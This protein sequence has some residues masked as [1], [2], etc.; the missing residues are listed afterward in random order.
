MK[1]NLTVIGVLISALLLCAL[2][3][4]ACSDELKTS[5]NNESLGTL[6]VQI[7]GEERTIAPSA[8]GLTYKIIISGNTFINETITGTKTYSLAPGSYWL[9]AE[10]YSGTN[11]VARFSEGDI[12]IA[13]GQTISKKLV[14]KPIY[15]A[16][17]SG[18]FSYNISYP[19]DKTAANNIG[20]S[21]AQIEIY[22]ID[23]PNDANTDQSYYNITVDFLTDPDKKTGTLTLPP[24]VY[25]IEV[26]IIST[27]YSGYTQLS[28]YRNEVVYVYPN[29]TTTATFAFTLPDFTADIY[30][31]GTAKL[32]NGNEDLSSTI[33][34]VN[35]YDPADPAGLKILETVPVTDG[36]WELT[37]N[38]QLYKKSGS[39]NSVTLDF[40]TEDEITY[41]KGNVYLDSYGYNNDV[42]LL[43]IIKQPQPS[44]FTAV[45]NSA[46]SSVA[47]TWTSVNNSNVSGYTVSRSINGGAY[48]LLYTINNGNTTTYTDNNLPGLLNDVG[49]TVDYQIVVTDN[50]GVTTRNSDPKKLAA[51]ITVPSSQSATQLSLGTWEGGNIA[52]AGGSQY[53][54]FTATAATQ[55]IH[56]NYNSTLT[57][58]YVRLYDSNGTV[59]GDN[60]TNLYSTIPYTSRSVTAGGNYYIRVWPY[61]NTSSGTYQIGITE[62]T[63]LPTDP[64]TDE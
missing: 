7:G 61:S 18:T 59:V 39:F 25:Q 33:T 63:S 41:S 1:K 14:L 6:I 35:L 46:Y 55:Y 28:V 4:T 17:V 60:Q 2:L 5:A 23:Y 52:T 47:L 37:I 9:S 26:S 50:R 42:E 43:F 31:A 53:F 12:N 48:T 3:F 30:L 49:G 62:S 15:T 44:T 10:A 19:D 58:V 38:S 34:S 45:A 29:L 32:I 13:A 11:I 57:D 51:A 54:K 8:E 22:P 20:Y 40:E 36:N 16:D 56:F 21:K 64:P 24:G 27:R